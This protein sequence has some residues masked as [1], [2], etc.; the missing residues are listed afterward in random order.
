MICAC[1]LFYLLFNEED[2]I[3]RYIKMIVAWV[4]SC[5]V[6]TE[7]LSMVE[8][9]TRRGIGVFWIGIDILVLLGVVWKYRKKDK[10]PFSLLKNS[11]MNGKMLSFCAFAIVLIVMAIK[12]VPYNYDSMTYHLPRIYHWL[13]NESVSHYATHID[14]QVANP[15]LS[16]FVN[17]HICALWGG[18]DRLFNLLQCCSYL[19][20]G[21]LV[22]YIAKEIGCLEKYCLIAS[23]LFYT[24]PIA[25]AE[26]FSTQVDN[27]SSLFLLCFV[28]II[29]KLLNPAERL[30]LNRTTW[31]RVIILSFCVAFGYLSK[32][33]V[34]VGM[35]FF[36]LWLLFVVIKRKDQMITVAIYFLTACLI[37][38]GL[39]LPT[40]LRNLHTFGAL[41]APVTSETRL[42]GTTN[43]RYM[44]VNFVKNFVFNMSTVWIATLNDHIVQGVKGFAQLLNVDIDNIVIAGAGRS[45]MLNSPQNYDHDF[46]VNPVIMYLFIICVIIYVIHNRKHWLKGQQNQYMIFTSA[47]FLM[48]CIIARWEPYNSRYMIGFFGILCPAVV[49]QLQQICEGGREVRFIRIQ[50]V[51]YL[52]C[53]FEF[54]GLLFYHGEKAISSERRDGSY[55]MSGNNVYA[56]YEEITDK[57]NENSYQNI[58]LMLGDNKWEYP[59]WVLLDNANNI[60]H[61]NVMNPTEKYEKWDFTPDVIIAEDYQISG[62]IVQ[63][64]GSQYQKIMTGS[65][66]QISLWE[67]IPE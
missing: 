2:C 52:L 13:Q 46:A 25:F 53:F 57:I 40:C 5:Y 3:E 49:A 60:E 31:S 38:G 64:H 41:L 1:I 14:R 51:I 27:F 63:C 56:D 15:V 61:V 9:V 21:I 48:F 65:N 50:T 36:A 44:L 54:C 23:V 24:M 67:R 6:S 59:Y 17:L 28:Y 39:L 10:K 45:Y 34:C 20:N 43:P 62:D 66:E 8:A 4:F 30:M 18:S 7:A 47:S 33:S 11:K 29:L 26:A 55:Y 19:T 58:G 37:L 35:A 12:T 16:E 32:P 42:V 22:Y